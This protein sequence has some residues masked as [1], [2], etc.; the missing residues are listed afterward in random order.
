MSRV[1]SFLP[2][3]GKRSM[4]SK[5]T[6]KQTNATTKTLRPLFLFDAMFMRSDEIGAKPRDEE[7]LEVSQTDICDRQLLS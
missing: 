4:Q 5:A 6:H 7:L 1:V 2:Q 3:V